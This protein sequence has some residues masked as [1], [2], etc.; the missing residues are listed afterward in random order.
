MRM[1]TR[2]KVGLA[3]AGGGVRGSAH[4]GIVKALYENHI[5]PEI[6]TGTSAG[7]IVASL[8]ALGYSPDKALKE[9]LN[10]N[11]IVDIAYGHILKNIFTPTHIEGFVKGD[12]LEK[13]LE[14]AFRGKTL[15]DVYQPLGIVATD[16]DK[17]EQTIFLSETKGF[18]AQKVNDNNITVMM[19]KKVP[20]STVTRASSGIPPVFIPKT[21]NGIRLVDGGL[22]NNLPSDVAVALGAEKVIS[23]DLG[24]ASEVITG[25]FI[26]IG[27]EAINILMA[28]VVDGN[29]GDFGYY[30]NP[31]IND[32]TVLEFDKIQECFDRGYAFGKSKIDEIVKYLEEETK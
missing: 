11:N 8:L 22:T 15:E 2:V 31:E 28:R 17:G 20:L 19:G 5:Y 14:N 26:D 18:Q 1:A 6:F 10:M 27:H 13:M 32:I 29:R 21:I 9:F 25:G 12:K 3:L 23:I 16:I 4:L 24:Y 30:M 7:S